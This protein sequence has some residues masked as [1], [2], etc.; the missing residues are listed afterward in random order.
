M[1]YADQGCAADPQP[2]SDQR[3]GHLYLAPPALAGRQPLPPSTRRLNA[4][5]PDPTL[6]HLLMITWAATGTR[7]APVP[8]R[9]RLGPPCGT[10]AARVGSGGG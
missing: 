1:Q 5:T 7:S 10:W 2:Q 3:Q 9:I 8:D 4:D 6:S